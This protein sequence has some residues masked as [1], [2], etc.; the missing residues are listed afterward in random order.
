MDF[1]RGA[2]GRAAARRE[3][4]EGPVDTRWRSSRSMS[5][6]VVLALHVVILAAILVFSRTR[7]WRAPAAPPLEILVLHA[8]APAAPPVPPPV[9]PTVHRAAPIPALPARASAL[10]PSAPAAPAAPGSTGPPTIDWNR[11]ASIVAAI[12]GSE[13]A[14]EAAAAAGAP[15]G[16]APPFAPPPLHYAGEEI[17]ATNGDTMVFIS[18]SCY[19]VSPK[20][21]PIV[22]ASN[23]GKPQQV[24]CIR[25]NKTARGDLFKD[26]PVYKKLHPDN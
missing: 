14:T 21:P 10:T 22:N 17:S 18:S 1:R 7:F 23:N 3:L 2:R 15:P 4:T 16:V 20:F 25:K 11:E 12:K 9:Q 6:L 24:Y 8:P 13:A 19:V 5:F 26:L